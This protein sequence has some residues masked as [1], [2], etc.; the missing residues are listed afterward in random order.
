M[1]AIN[2]VTLAQRHAGLDG[3]LLCKRFQ[4]YE[5]A[6]A[7]HPERWSGATRNWEPVMTVHLNPGK[8]IMEAVNKKEQKPQLKKKSA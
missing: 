5:A 1:L 7:K 8:N 2:F 4:V 3:A 6:K